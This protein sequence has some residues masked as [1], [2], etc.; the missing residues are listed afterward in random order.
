MKQSSFDK[1]LTTEPD[2]DKSMTRQQIETDVKMC[3]CCDWNEEL[4]VWNVTEFCEIHADLS[5]EICG[6]VVKEN[7]ACFEMA[8]VTCGE[9]FLNNFLLTKKGNK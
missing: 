4:S 1:W 9:C 8:R 7:E 2:M 3:S 6:H 5:C